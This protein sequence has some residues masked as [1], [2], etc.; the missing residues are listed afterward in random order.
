MTKLEIENKVYEYAKRVDYNVKTTDAE[1]KDRIN[2]A[3]RD[4]VAVAFLMSVQ[5]MEFRFG[6]NQKVNLILAK[7]RSD[8][9][10]IIKKSVRYSKSISRRLNLSMDLDIED[11]DSDSWVN[12]ERY[13]KTYLQR[14]A[15]Y[16]NRLKY[17]LE[18]YTAVGMVKKLSELEI[19][20][21]FMLN[22]KS[23][24]TVSEILDA[25]GYSAVRASGILLVGTGGITSAY[26][27]ILRLNHDM[28]M[29][30]YA[31]SNNKTWGKNGLF[32]YILVVNDSKTC[33][34][35][36]MNIGVIFPAGEYVIPQ[37]LNCRCREVILLDSM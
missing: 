27:S 22:I 4:I 29:A 13:G 33:A 36:Q 21:W 3:V 5:G 26:K 32:K 2:T 23:P 15:V 35:C 28:I 17:E 16:S 25:E 20:N 11:W 6:M 10:A 31:I 34:A 37:H 8:I 14:L 30:G 9:E 19:T 1:V 24:H 12:S 7:M 18:I